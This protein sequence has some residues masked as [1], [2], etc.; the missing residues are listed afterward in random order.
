MASTALS[1]A[2]MVM[3]TSTAAASPAG[4][5]ATVTPI[6]APRSSALARVRFQTVTGKPAATRF[7]TIGVPIRPRPMNPTR[8][9]APPSGSCG[10]LAA[11]AVEL[12]A[13]APRVWR[14]AHALRTRQV[15]TADAIVGST[16]SEIVSFGLAVLVA[17]VVGLAAVLSNR[18]S[19]RLRIPAAA[20]FL[21]CAALA[22]DLMPRL[23]SLRI[24][25]VERVVTVALVVILFDGGMH[26]GWRRLRPVAGATVWLGVAGT[27]LTAAALAV[28][29]QLLFGVGWRVALLLGT[30]LAPTDPAVVFSVLGRREVAG[31]SGVLLE[32]ES[33]TNDPVGI[34]LIVA[35]LAAS[36]SGIQAAGAVALQFG[37][38]MLVGVVVGVVGGW[39]LLHVVRRIGRAS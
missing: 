22:S 29:A 26:I 17:G 11:M 1:S 30:A 23:G 3:E 24:E 16:V 12:G 9:C 6:S 7:L 27:L 36:G 32:G 8:I 20:I 14:S 37:L 35:L 2:T 39:L 13:T 31:R 15:A 28:C 25:T 21:L 38:Q 4:S 5:S 33:G 18:L 34:A 10:A 19:E